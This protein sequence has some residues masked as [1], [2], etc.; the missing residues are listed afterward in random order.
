[1]AASSLPIL[2]I[3]Q[4]DYLENVDSENLPY[5]YQDNLGCGVTSVVD[6]VMDLNTGNEF[7][8][9]QYRVTGTQSNRKYMTETFHNELRN[10]RSLEKHR[11]IIQIWAAYTTETR[12]CIL[13]FPVAEEDLE[14]Y[15]SRLRECQDDPDRHVAQ[16]SRMTTVLVEAF[17][18]LSSGLAFMQPHRIRHRDIKPSNILVHKGTVLYTDFGLSLDSKK[19]DNSSSEGISY[20]TKKY[21]AP[22]VAAES[23]RDSSSDVFSLG[24]VFIKIFSAIDESFTSQEPERYAEIM[25]EFHSKLAHHTPNRSDIAFL[26]NLI[27]WMTQREPSCRVKAQRVWDECAQHV[28]CRCTPCFQSQPS[29]PPAT[30]SGQGYWTDWRPT[31]HRPGHYYAYLMHPEGFIMETRY[32]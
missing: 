10:I 27:I 12:L 2:L 31:R 6:K 7:A 9:K 32:A 21:R 18:C 1:M 30:A 25:D 20:Q 29:S 22:E 3:E 28:S 14:N 24:C 13:L 26:P 23:L 19:L 15:L 5:E 16:I 17:G 11:H 4:G 8:R